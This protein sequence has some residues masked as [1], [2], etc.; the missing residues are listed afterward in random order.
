MIVVSVVSE[1]PD[2]VQ[3]PTGAVGSSKE[4][5]KTLLKPPTLPQATSPEALE[6]APKDSDAPVGTLTPALASMRVSYVRGIIR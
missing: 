6:Y 4:E 5:L 1:Q 2:G 3:P